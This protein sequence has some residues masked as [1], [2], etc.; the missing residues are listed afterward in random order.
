MSDTNR[1]AVSVIGVDTLPNFQNDIVIASTPDLGSSPDTVVSD[2]IR[3]DRQVNDLVKVNEE[4]GGTI[5]TEFVYGV[6]EGLLY[7][8]A[9]QA[10][11]EEGES[12]LITNSSVS[13]GV[14]SLGAT[15]IHTG[16]EIGDWV[17]FS[18]DQSGDN[19][20]L[21]LVTN[22]FTDVL[23]VEPGPPTVDTF[24][25]ANVKLLGNRVNGTTPVEFTVEKHYEDI[26]VF[27]Y[28]DGVYV[29]SQTIT[30]PSN[31]LITNTWTF[32][33]ESHESRNS[34]RGGLT[35]LNIAAS[36]PMNTSDNIAALLI[37]DAEVD[38]VVTEVSITISNNARYRNVVGV[39][40]AQSIGFG[41][42]NVTG[43]MSIYFEDTTNLDRV[44]NN[45]EFSLAL[46]LLDSADDPNAYVYELP[47][48]KFSS[49]IPEV[50]GKN[51]DVMMTLE[52][53]AMRDPTDGHTIKLHTSSG[54]A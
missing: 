37:N 54:I 36:P 38:G 49:G 46:A 27:E 26:G 30:A 4:V 11:S 25:N 40:G 5:E 34:G 48:C 22:T 29:D 41:E 24:A 43:S 2:I 19:V 35:N 42:F 44:L 18:E 7:R 32:M 16:V 17:Q 28:L 39:L 47:R 12:I 6:F 33:G 23:V 21:H 50:S 3:S 45:T 51:E 10:D 52:F 53:Q 15:G 31:G 9:L 1:V 14:S 8:W 20:T 13:A